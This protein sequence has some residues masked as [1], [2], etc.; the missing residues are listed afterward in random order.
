MLVMG[1]RKMEFLG[2]CGR[3]EVGISVRPMPRFVSRQPFNEHLSI[4]TLSIAFKTSSFVVWLVCRAAEH[5][6]RSSDHNHSVV[7]ILLPDGESVRSRVARSPISEEVQT[8]H[9]SDRC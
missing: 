3:Y 7:A 5:F 9:I 8:L 4:V 2:V 6:F 1:Q